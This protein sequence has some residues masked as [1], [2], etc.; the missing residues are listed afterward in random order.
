MDTKKIKKV[1]LHLHL[2]G[3]LRPSTVIDIAKKEGIEL[4]SYD[5]KELI[6]YL[7][8]DETNK[9]LVEYLK[10][11]NLPLKVM[12]TRE[13]LERVTFELLEDLAKDN[14]IYVELRFAPHLHTKKGLNL[15]EIVES[16]NAGIFRAENTYPIKANVLLCIMRHMEVSLGYEIVDLA[17]KYLGEKVCGI[18]LA[19]DEFNYSV[20]LF[21][22]VFARAKGMDIPFTIHSGEARGP[23]SIVDALSVGAERLGHGIRAYENKELLEKLKENRITLECCPISNLNTQ[24]FH[25]FHDYPLKTYLNNGLKATI[26]TDN[27]TVSNTNYQKEIDFLEKYTPLTL[28]EIYLAN[29]NAIEGAFISKE[30]KEEL[31]KKLN[32]N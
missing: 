17:K 32:E 30:E 4:P 5:E 25:D 24:I 12:Q 22:D 16:V 6:K 7:S 1:E 21:K 18:D 2:D 31:L 8:V 27:R 26:N 9:D 15:S 14:Y 3:S 28:E 10:K 19:G 11:F 20:T 29:K 23:E 13:N